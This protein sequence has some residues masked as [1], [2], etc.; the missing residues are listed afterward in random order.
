MITVGREEGVPTFSQLDG[1]PPSPTSPSPV[2]PD[3][4]PS[5][6]LP[7]PCFPDPFPRCCHCKGECPCSMLLGWLVQCRP[8]PRRYQTGPYLIFVNFFNQAKVL[9]RKFYTKDRVNYGK[10]ILRQN[11]VNCDLLGQANYKDQDY[12]KFVTHCM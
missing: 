12:T 10:L 1:D 7:P 3:S 2:T 5:S 11:S 6:P 9:D 4:P 8:W